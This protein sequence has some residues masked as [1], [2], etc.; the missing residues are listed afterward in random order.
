VAALEAFS[1]DVVLIAGGRPKVRDFGALAKAAANRG[2]DLVLIGEAAEMIAEAAREAG[3][4]NIHVA[5]DLA[6]AVARA[7]ERA[8]PGDVVLLSPACAS[9][10]MFE[11][12]AERGRTFKSLMA[13]MA[14]NKGID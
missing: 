14:A 9:F 8:R 6:D 5:V 1:K 7:Y 2:A 3:V 10:D 13:E 4:A 11:S 12:M